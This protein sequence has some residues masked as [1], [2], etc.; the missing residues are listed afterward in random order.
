MIISLQMTLNV[1]VT[2]CW[3]Q[4]FFH[5][6]RYL[7]RVSDVQ[8]AHALLQQFSRRVERMYGASIV[9]HNMHLHCHLRECLLD[10]II[11]GCSALKDITE[12]LK[13]FQVALDL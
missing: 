5:S 9:T 1:G 10:Y 4:G 7:S 2:L 13:I 3:H 11:F 12:Y 8:L 6:Y